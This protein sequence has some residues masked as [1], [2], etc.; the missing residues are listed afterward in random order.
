MYNATQH[1]D[2]IY[3]REQYGDYINKLSSFSPSVYASNMADQY[4]SAMYNARE[5]VNARL[6][7]LG[8]VVQHVS[9]HISMLPKMCVD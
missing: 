5:L 4:T 3:L 2:V 8:P 9:F 1:P 7:G 6:A